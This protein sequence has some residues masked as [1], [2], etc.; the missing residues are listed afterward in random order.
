MGLFARLLGLSEGND[1]TGRQGS[2]S[3]RP[4]GTGTALA[5][6]GGAYGRDAEEPDPGDDPLSLENVE[7]AM[8]ARESAHGRAARQ[9]VM[10]ALDD[11][12][13]ARK[14]V[15]AIRRIMREGGDR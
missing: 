5:P 12:E 6:A 3:A 1:G 8:E 4:P 14:L 15:G 2:G 13:Q 11:E 10:S 7:A 9:K